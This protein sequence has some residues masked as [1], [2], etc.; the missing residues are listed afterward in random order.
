[1]LAAVASVPT[2][3]M[4]MSM[5]TVSASARSRPPSPNCAPDPIQNPI[6]TAQ[7]STVVADSA[8]SVAVVRRHPVIKEAIDAASGARIAASSKPVINPATPAACPGRHRRKCGA[9]GRST[10][11]SR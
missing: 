9:A 4:T 8:V 11:R 7:A 5:T 1:M 2:I 3:P 10:R 6:A